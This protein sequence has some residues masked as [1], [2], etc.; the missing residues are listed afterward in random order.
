MTKRNWRGEGLFD[1]HI[2]NHNPLTEAK[3]R[4]I[5]EVIEDPAYCLTPH[6]LLGL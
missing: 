5:A 3:A 6:G 4:G 2:S 1:L